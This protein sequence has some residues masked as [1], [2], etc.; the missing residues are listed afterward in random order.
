M[1]TTSATV[2]AVTTSSLVV[3]AKPTVMAWV[4]WWRGRG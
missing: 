1:T 2:F 4:R 3:L